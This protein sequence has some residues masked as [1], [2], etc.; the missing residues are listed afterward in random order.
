MHAQSRQVRD[1]RGRP[2]IDLRYRYEEASRLATQPH[3]PSRG[4]T[5]LVRL[6]THT[7]GGLVGLRM[8][9]PGNARGRDADTDAEHPTSGVRNRNPD[10]E[11]RGH[12]PAFT[13]RR[14]WNRRLVE[15]ESCECYCADHK[16]YA[17]GP[18][19]PGCSVPCGQADDDSGIPEQK[20]HRSS[21]RHTTPGGTFD[22]RACQR[23]PRPSRAATPLERTAPPSPAP[24]RPETASQ[25][26]A[27]PALRY[28]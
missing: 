3:G 16:Q 13:R 4:A 22:G 15:G 28:R 11:R 14:I 9:S 25:R 6:S 18:T 21:V 5:P 19:P 20:L 12:R 24:P 2:T 26:S 23:S 8:P 17:N 10:P 27:I 7:R 1:A